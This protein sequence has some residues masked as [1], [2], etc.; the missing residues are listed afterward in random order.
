MNLSQS[1]YQYSFDFSP[2]EETPVKNGSLELNIAFFGNE[3]HK[4]KIRAAVRE[5]LSI[6]ASE[7]IRIPEEFTIIIKTIQAIQALGLNV[8]VDVDTKKAELS[9]VQQKEEQDRYW[10]RTG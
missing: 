1:D 8:D 10:D 7:P 6:D 3:T 4:E 9:V 5:V 2:S